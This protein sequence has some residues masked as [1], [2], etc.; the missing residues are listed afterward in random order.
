MK[1]IHTVIYNYQIKNVLP[2]PSRNQ[3]LKIKPIRQ[4]CP[5]DPYGNDYRIA[6]HQNFVPKGYRNQV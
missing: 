5:T 6:T 2:N 4:L 1:A 3:Y